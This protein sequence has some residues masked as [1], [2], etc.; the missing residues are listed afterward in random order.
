MVKDH[1]SSTIYIEYF[2]EYLEFILF[3]REVYLL[4]LTMDTTFVQ[5]HIRVLRSTLPLI[6]LLN[7]QM[8]LVVNMGCTCGDPWVLKV[9]SQSNV[10][11]WPPLTF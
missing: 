7:T 1:L 3:I 8:V 11:H 2:G 6:I 10:P 5:L 9:S 4:C